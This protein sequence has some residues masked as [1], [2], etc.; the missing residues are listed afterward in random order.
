MFGEVK[1]I[2]LL[3]LLHSF[4]DELC[5]F[6]ESYTGSVDIIVREHDLS[7]K[8]EKFFNHIGA[9]IVGTQKAEPT[10]SFNV[11]ALTDAV[12][13]RDKKNAWLLYR[14]AIEQGQAPEALSGMVWWQ[15]KSMLLVARE[16]NPKGMKPYVVTKTQRALK[17]YTNEDLEQLAQTL[18]TAIH[19]PRAGNGRAEEWIEQVLLAL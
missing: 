17:N 13:A 18:I 7:S 1:T 6:F 4:H 10:A 5:A 3:Y 19:E 8:D 9:R 2:V 14:E 15:V 11:W 12:L 16:G